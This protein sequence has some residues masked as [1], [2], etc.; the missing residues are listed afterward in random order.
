[1]PP[2]ERRRDETAWLSSHVKYVSGGG[3]ERERERERE[4]KREREREKERRLW[5]VKARERISLI[6]TSEYVRRERTVGKGGQ[7]GE[8]EEEGAS[9]YL[10]I[11]V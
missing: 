10:S 1:M 6:K 2:G 8:E 7:A 4:R 11:I 5:N 3:G 9:C